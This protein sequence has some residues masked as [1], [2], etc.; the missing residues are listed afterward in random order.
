MIPEII[1]G[2][3][4]TMAILAYLVIR[5]KLMQNAILQLAEESGGVDRE[6]VRDQLKVFSGD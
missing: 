3:A 5:D 6:A 2:N 4:D 1:T